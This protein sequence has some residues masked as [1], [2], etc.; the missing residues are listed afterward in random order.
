MVMGAFTFV[1]VLGGI[2]AC[3]GDGEA[4]HREEGLYGGFHR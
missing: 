4:W 3:A 1:A 2:G